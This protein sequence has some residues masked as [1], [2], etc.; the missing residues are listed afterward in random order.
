MQTSQQYMLN[1]SIEANEH[2]KRKKKGIFKG[3][4][5]VI[6]KTETNMEKSQRL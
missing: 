4:K 5:V 3:R 1:T 2:L 6:K